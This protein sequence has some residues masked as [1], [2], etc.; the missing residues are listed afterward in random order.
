MTFRSETNGKRPA[1]RRWFS[2]DK[3]RA[4]A[5]EGLEDAF[6]CDMPDG[7]I[8]RIAWILREFVR[9]DRGEG[10]YDEVGR[11]PPFSV[12]ERNSAILHAARLLSDRAS[13]HRK[14]YVKT[15]G[16]RCAAQNETFYRNK[17]T[18]KKKG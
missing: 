18:K 13:G 11:T 12:K 1:R 17:K 5:P 4:E 3:Y 7:G 14:T 15:D 6:S 8:P 2:R 9:Y 10:K 16:F